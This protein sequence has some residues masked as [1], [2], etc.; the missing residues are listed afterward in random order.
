LTASTAE[1]AFATDMC[2]TIVAWNREAATLLG[3]RAGKAV[4]RRCYRL[5]AGT[6]LFGNSFCSAACPVLRAVRRHEPLHR[7][8]AN[9]RKADGT[10][11]C[12]RV[13]A[14]STPLLSARRQCVLHVLEPCVNCGET[15]A[16]GDSLSATT[17]GNGAANG[18]SKRE[19]EVLGL[20]SQGSSTGDMSLALCIS[21][22]TV[23]NHV[24]H[25]LDKLGAHSRLDA[26]CVARRQ[27]IL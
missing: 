26:V 24:Q 7:F 19:F 11:V 12:V 14:L 8:P 10:S 2:G 20:M 23:R 15:K 22:A 21:T 9:L 1:P 5:L 13:S 6:D 27:G 3:Y 16:L 25:L 17:A 4:G 18:I